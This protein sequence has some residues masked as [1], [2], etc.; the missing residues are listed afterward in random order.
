MYRFAPRPDGWARAIPGGSSMYCAGVWDSFR[1]VCKAAILSDASLCSKRAVALKLG[2]PDTSRSP[3]PSRGPRPQYQ[4]QFER[5]RRGPRLG[6]ATDGDTHDSSQ[7]PRPAD[8][9]SSGTRPGARFHSRLDPGFDLWPRN[10][11]KRLPPFRGPAPDRQNHAPLVWRSGRRLDRLP[12]VFPSRAPAR[13]SLRSSADP[14]PRFTDSGSDPCRVT[15]REPSSP[16][17]SA[18]EFLETNRLRRPG[19]PDSCVPRNHRRR[20]LPPAVIDEPAAASMVHEVPG[21]SRSL[22]FLRTLERRIDARAA[23]LSLAH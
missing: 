9:R 14:Q 10:I 2:P 18:E 3:G 17:D 7:G 21:G 20:A 13:I 15:R 5:V 8:R 22:P 6:Y 4:S 12:A 23:Q 1:A 19:L 11:L 16:A